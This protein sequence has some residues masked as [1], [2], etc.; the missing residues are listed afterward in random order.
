MTPKLK[1]PFSWLTI[2]L[3]LTFFSGCQKGIN[4]EQREELLGLLDENLERAREMDDDRTAGILASLE[5]GLANLSSD[6]P[7]E[8]AQFDSAGRLQ[9]YLMVTRTE[10]SNELGLRLRRMLGRA[11]ALRQSI[12][13][14]PAGLANPPDYEY[15]REDV[16]EIASPEH[17]GIEVVFIITDSHRPTDL[18]AD[19]FDGGHLQGFAVGWSYSDNAPACAAEVAV[20]SGDVEYVSIG[21]DDSVSDQLHRNLEWDSIETV[22]TALGLER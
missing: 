5:S 2:L 7:D 15:L 4:P 14:D 10:L 11:A 20:R 3:I 16:D 18:G 1:N 13:R 6:C 21:V 22:A 9:N 8:F 17:D 12:E 19:T